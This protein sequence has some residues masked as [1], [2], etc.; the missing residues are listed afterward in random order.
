MPSLPLPEITL[1]GAGRGPP[2]RIQR[3]VVVDEHAVLPVA[4]R[5]P[6]RAELPGSLPSG[7]S[8]PRMSVPIRLPS[9]RFSDAETV[10]STTP[11]FRLPETTLPAP[12]TVPPTRFP[13]LVM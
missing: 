10:E 5:Q 4:D 2:D 1:P 6:V 7:L 3:R 13:V 11:L 8:P 12:A 9:T